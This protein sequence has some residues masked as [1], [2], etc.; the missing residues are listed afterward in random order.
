[1]YGVIFDMD[2]VL[3]DSAEAHLRSWQIMAAEQGRTMSAEVFRATFGRRSG[4]IIAEVF[5]IADPVEIR[6]LD[7]R[8][9]AIYRDLIRQHIP[10]MDGAVALVRAL[11]AAGFRL[12]IG[13]SGPQENVDLVVDGLGLG[14]CFDARISARQVTR[15]KPDPQVFLLAAEGL[16][17]PP[18][19]CAV[20]E[21]AP[22]GIEAAR[23]AGAVAIGL[24]GTHPAAA[25]DGADLLVS[26]LGELTPER[27]MDLID[28]RNRRRF[29]ASG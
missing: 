22:A 20:V 21:D 26:A 3:V 13:S 10:A 9:E 25:L 18:G 1:M 5:G 14:D 29:P 8:K 6:R 7:D 16:G 12:A 4:D 27:V 2:G 17:L 19:R 11:R 15:G 28:S 23:A 24:V